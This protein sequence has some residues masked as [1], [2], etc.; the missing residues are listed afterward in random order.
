MN[1]KFSW[2]QFSDL[3]IFDGSTDWTLMKATFSGLSDIVSPDFLVF[4]GDFRHLKHNRSYDSALRFI[5]EMVTLFR[6]SKEDV[7]LIPGNHDVSDYDYRDTYVQAVKSELGNIEKYREY[8]QNDAADL[9]NAFNDYTQFVKDF[10]QKDVVDDRVKKPADVVCIPWKN[11]IN[12]VLL[13]S[14]LLSTSSRDNSEIIDINSFSSLKI[15]NGLPTIALMHHDVSC[16]AKEFQLRLSRIISMLDI[17]AILCGDTHIL[18]KRYIFR[19][20]APNK[21]IPVIVC[22]KS[23]AE[24]NDF[25]SDLSVIE[26]S[27]CVDGNV[28]VQVYKYNNDN[29]DEYGFVKSSDFYHHVDKPFSFPMLFK[30]RD[31]IAQNILIAGNGETIPPGNVSLQHRKKRGTSRTNKK[32]KSIWLPDAELASGKQT[33]FDSYTETEDVAQ[34][35]EMD[36]K[37]LGIS[38]VK[39][40]GKTFILQVKRVKSS[41]KY[42]CLPQCAT[43]SI[44]NNWATERITF[45]TYNQ[46]QTE[47]TY[48]NLVLLWINAIRC[49]V[50]NNLYYEQ[51]KRLSEE[52]NQKR[53][54][55]SQ[56]KNNIESKRKKQQNDNMIKKMVEEYEKKQLITPEIAELFLCEENLSLCTVITNVLADPGWE[57]SINNY[58]RAIK[59]I[60]DRSLIYY[61]QQSPRPK[62]IAVFIDKVDQSILQ[63][64][65]EPPADCVVCSRQNSYTECNSKRKSL[66]YC[67]DESGCQSKSNCC[68]GCELFA[69]TKSNA[70]LRI[71]DESCAAR[72]KHINIWQYLQLALMHAS[73]VLSDETQGRISVFY[74]MR[75]EVFS[76]EGYRLGEQNNKIAGRTLKLKYTYSEQEQIF[77]ECIQEQDDLYLLNPAEKRIPGKQ[78]YAFVGVSKLCHPYC[79]TKEGLN[80]SETVFESIYRHSFD[81]SRDIQR[82]GEYL[83]KRLDMIRACPTEH[84][85]EECVKQLIEDLAAKLA[86][87]EKQSES[88]VNPS[89][90]TEKMRYL[91]NYWADNSNF[92][93]LLSLIDRNLLFE[94][95]MKRIC[96]KV[97]NVTSCPAEGCKNT[98]C[99]RHP[100]TVL[101]KLGYMGYIVQ[102]TNNENVDQQVFLDAGEISYFAETDDLMAAARVA[103]IIHPALSKTIQ[104]KYNK[105]F[106]HFSGFI[107]GKNL[108]VETGVIKQMLE[109][110]AVLNT[111]DFI[112]KYYYN[113]TV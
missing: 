79:K 86:Y 24:P 6:L 37:Y 4:T 64:N 26:Y 83:T 78:A 77:N 101:Y 48:D 53:I 82:F 56:N 106:L 34:F 3:H 89:Y 73:T 96:Q 16:I 32:S 2:L 71:Y 62:D 104:R 70:G 22:G 35:F 72:I 85:R 107:L 1:N 93:R 47:K 43:P 112:K 88:T 91:P 31:S 39:G 14:A 81:R 5:N 30:Q 18:Q 61:S 7:F 80:Q 98:F 94:E 55:S 113:P 58:N 33:R 97:N 68:Y 52:N 87:C 109:D 60:C 63:T 46:L 95:D 57:K 75:E 41:Q 66:E 76:C 12:I 74:T 15:E 50:V 36:S 59:V 103:Y 69:S 45:Q 51:I 49:Y 13:N 108:P 20:S 40:I 54:K 25:Y 90:Y 27:Y 17:S 111:H 19:N 102:N 65:A 28:Y 38:S 105:S 9:R 84:K 99:K 23:A 44:S 92:E 110:K 11:Q 10:Y 21:A 8:M 100:F 67:S 42:L 29:P